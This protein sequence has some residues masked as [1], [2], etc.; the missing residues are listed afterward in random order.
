MTGEG[1]GH[2]ERRLVGAVTS[3]SSGPDEVA[4]MQLGDVT[5]MT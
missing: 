2:V 1:P 4:A 5:S 3:S